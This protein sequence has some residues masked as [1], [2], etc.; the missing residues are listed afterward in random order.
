MTT[1][2]NAGATEPA[3]AGRGPDREFLMLWA[4]SRRAIEAELAARRASG[5]DLL[6]V[7]RWIKSRVRTRPPGAGA[8][9]REPGDG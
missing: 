2:A 5:I 9:S 4:E 6:P 7:V 3:P 8:P 1:P